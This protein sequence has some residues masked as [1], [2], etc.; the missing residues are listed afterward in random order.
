MQSFSKLSTILFLCLV[1]IMVGC[2]T[3]T[4]TPLDAEEI[5]DPKPDDFEV[6]V[7]GSD[8]A[9]DF[10]LIGSV[11]CQDSAASSIWNWWTDQQ[12]LIVEM[13]AE[14]VERLVE[15][16]REVGGDALIGLTHDL[17]YGGSSGGV[18]LGVGMGRGPVGVGVGTS[19]LGGNPKIVVVSYGEVGVVK[20]T[21]SS[22]GEDS[23]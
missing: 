13:K 7:V 11:S 17:S 18:G 22:G 6:Q 21:S 15:R 10:R 20:G 1:P 2:S 16:I 3:V 4:F 19:L 9:R 8:G 23:P 12:A 14:N 5:F